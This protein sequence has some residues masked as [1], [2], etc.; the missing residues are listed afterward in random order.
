MRHPF[1]PDG[2][3]ELPPPEYDGQSNGTGQKHSPVIDYHGAPRGRFDAISTDARYGITNDQLGTLRR[4]M[5]TNEDGEEEEA[6]DEHGNPIYDHMPLANFAALVGEEIA[7]DDGVELKRAFSLVGALSGGPTFP[8]ARIEAKDFEALKWAVERWGSRAVLRA[9]RPIRDMAREAIQ[10][11]SKPTSRHVYTHTGWRQLDDGHRVYLHAGGAIG[12]EGLSVELGGKLTHFRLPD[13]DPAISVR[14]A[15]AASLSV[16]HIAPRAVTMPLLAAAYLA[17]LSSMLAPDFML[18]IVGRTGSMKSTLCALAQQHFGAAFTRT[19]LP[20]DWLSTPTSI[21]NCIFTA[22]DALTVVDDYAPQADRR[23]QQEMDRTAQWIIRSVGNRSARSR[24]RHDLTQRPDRPPRGVV[25]STAEDLPPGHSTVGRLVVVK[26]ERD[27]IDTEALSAVQAK[28]AMCAHAMRAY[29]EHIAAR[30][31][32][33]V[34]EVRQIHVEHIAEMRKMDHAHSRQAEAL[35]FI[36][37]GIEQLGRF[38]RS[39]GVLDDAELA[40]L[41]EDARQ[42]IGDVSAYQSQAVIEADPTER[43]MVALRSMLATGRAR[44]LRRKGVDVEPE[45][46]EV[47]GWQDEDHVL[48]DPDAARRAVVIFYQQAGENFATSK[49]ALH[50]QLD[51]RGYLHTTTEAGKRRLDPKVTCGGARRRVLMLSRS[52][53]IEI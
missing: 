46:G 1:D 52:L 51:R 49:S 41:R 3:L 17:P 2:G 35:A 45:A 8:E 19:N 29:V 16:L 14:D 30:Y 10:L 25:I 9:G 27:R 33:L 12:A 48:L 38:A 15:V 36:L 23:R 7:L 32:D 39:V 26:V 44:L 22:K 42:A 11:L 31:D 37:T 50:E 4:Q 24:S 21:E 18:W 20:V 40:R 13:P 47:V 34:V 6:C 28:S 53:L 43:Y 5:T